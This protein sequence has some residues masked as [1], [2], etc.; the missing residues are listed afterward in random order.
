MTAPEQ[1]QG[2]GPWWLALRVI[3]EPAEVFRQLAARPRALVPLLLVVIVT[4]VTA[5]AIPADTLREGTRTQMEAAQE[6]APDRITDED[7]EQ[8]VE[9]A[10]RT[11][12]RLLIFVGQ[13]AFM[14]IG[15]LVAAAVLM[16]IFGA[17]AAEPLKFKDEFAIT[18]HAWMP[19]LLGALLI[20]ALMRFAGM[21]QY[22]LSL[23]FLF[24]EESS[25]FL[26]QL[27]NQFGLFGA[28]NVFL[29]ALGNQIRVGAKGIGTPL[30]IV[31]GLWVLVNLVFAGLASFFQG[32]A[33]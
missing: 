6:R 14:L 23:G 9:G 1:Q 25:P 13:A 4:A 7:I 17:M 2:K 22:Q 20:V 28:W 10:A 31:G 11:T 16:L 30:A 3:D 27:G 24:S 33:G 19:Q 26:H 15:L 18:A 21:G 5:F 29:L 12:A 32:L 8:R